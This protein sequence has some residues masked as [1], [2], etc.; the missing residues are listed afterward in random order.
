[1]TDTPNGSATIRQLRPEDL[2]GVVGIDEKTLG[3]SRLGFF[4]K[5]LMAVQDNPDSY[6]TLA[7]DQGDRLVGYL[8]ARVNRGEFG[9]VDATAAVD[10]MG[11]AEGHQQHGVGRQL[12]GALDGALQEL[13]ISTLFSQVDWTNSALLGFFGRSG[14]T[15]A[16]RVLLHGAVPEG[17]LAANSGDEAGEVE[18]SLDESG[19]LDF[20]D[21]SGDQWIA[22]ARDRMLIRSMTE[23]D[24]APIAA[25]DQQFTG[26]DRTPYFERAVGQALA[27][28]GVRVSLVAEVDERV[29]GYIIARVDNG[30]FGQTEPVA[31]MDTLG[32]DPDV[33]HQDVA[34]ALM[35]QLYM[36]LAA[37]RIEEVRTVVAWDAF[38]ILNFLN[39]NGFAP[40]Q[41]LAL[42]RKI[43]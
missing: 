40:A 29:A 27:E 7:A 8:I 17:A 28:S 3:R 20:S 1:M 9:R 11:V 37:L 22:L 42:W 43:H 15:L 36:N 19:E 33:Q 24:L 26:I 16:P 13:G 21:P 38:D 41:R 39:E 31:V 10:A 2:H 14:F 25:I 35:S 30:E 23:K 34:S 4:D 32:V 12:M 5:R 6:V 18:D